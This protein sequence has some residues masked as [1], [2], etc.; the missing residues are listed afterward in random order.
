M[1]GPSLS[2]PVTVFERA[3]LGVDIR[4][5][6]QADLLA[7]FR[8]EKASFPQPWP[9]SAFERFLDEPGFLVACGAD[10]H[11]DD[12]GPVLGYVVADCIRNHGRP[13]G[14]IKDLAV[15]PD[16]R[17]AGIGSALLRRAL[18]TL[19]AQGAR[20]VKL[21]VRRTNDVARSLYD[22]VGFEYLKT[23]P[24]YYADGEDAIVYVL[25]LH[26]RSVG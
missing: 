22:G 14:H 8:I 7:V 15:H 9:F 5:A 16:R 3:D 13:L 12:A 21:E 6:V 18:H 1:S 26:A 23:V 19:D 2:P 24:R 20:N 11:A 10:G 17:G 4:P 25:D